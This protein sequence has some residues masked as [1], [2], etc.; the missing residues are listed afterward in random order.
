MLVLVFDFF[1]FLTGLRTLGSSL[2]ILT[3]ARGSLRIGSLAMFPGDTHRYDIPGISPR[4]VFS[5]NSYLVPSTS[6]Y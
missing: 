2:Q 1:F 3:E 6:L 4:G 5:S